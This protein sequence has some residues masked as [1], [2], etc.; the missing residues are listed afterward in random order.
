[1]KNR[2]FLCFVLILLFSSMVIAAPPWKKDK[3][4]EPTEP[5]IIEKETIII[6]NQ[7]VPVEQEK[8]LN[9][10]MIGVI[11]TIIYATIAV[12]VFFKTKRE[13]KLWSQLYESVKSSEL[14]TL[15]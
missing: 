8:G 3:E 12:G 11:I 1:M 4:P 6:Q 15:V 14:K 10:E 2:M 5:T 13:R 9:W 7:T